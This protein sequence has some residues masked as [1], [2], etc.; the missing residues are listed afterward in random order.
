MHSVR[1]SGAAVGNNTAYTAMVVFH[2]QGVQSILG[3]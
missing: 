2:Q 1:F 3:G